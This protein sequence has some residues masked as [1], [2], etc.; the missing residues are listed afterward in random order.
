[1]QALIWRYLWGSPRPLIRW[2]LRLSFGGLALSAWAW[3]VVASVF[4][5][6]SSFLEEVFQR[7][8]PHIRLVG[9]GLTDSLREALESLP[10]VEAA[11]G[12]YERVAI[13]RYG[14]RQAVVRLRLVDEKYPEVSRIGTQL[15]W[16]ENFPLREKHLLVGA[17][18]AGQ[19]ALADLEEEALWVY[20]IPSGRRIAFAGMEGLLKQRAQV[21]GIFSV[22]KEY[23]DTWVIARQSDWK[24]IQGK[25][26]DLIEIHLASSVKIESFVKVLRRRLGGNVEIQDPR[27]QHEGL[28]RVLA[29]EKVLA[30]IGLFFLLLLT[31]MGI[32][33]SLSAFLLLGRRD[34]ALYQALGASHQWVRQFLQ[35]L[36]VVLL[37]GAT[38]T[39]FF[40]GTVTVLLQDKFKIVK[41][42]GGEGFLLQYFPVRLAWEDF[43]WLLGLVG[44][45]AVFVSV[46]IR[47]Q[48][49]RL[50]LRSAL[51]GD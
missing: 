37:L 25:E 21:Q 39:G 20:L 44:L 29:Q 23:D 26:Y 49:R 13:L 8:D 6:F 42:R 32:I 16:G 35:R 19:L 2:L 3:I 4:N 9:R 11:S 47:Y 50:D 30:R 24:D 27:R 14:G 18:V 33:S 34:W 51:Q 48:L 43:L 12:V 17:G 31:L 38:F 1:M 45:A 10:E 28:Y 5:G 7:A 22:Q 15:L 40:L 41:L 36:A 46:Y